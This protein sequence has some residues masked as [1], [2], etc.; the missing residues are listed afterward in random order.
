MDTKKLRV[1]KSVYMC[2]QT[3]KQYESIFR[4]MIPHFTV[5]QVYP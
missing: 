5:H 2:N 1:R 4:Q 3:L